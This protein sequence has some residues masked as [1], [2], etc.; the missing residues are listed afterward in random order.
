M[1]TAEKPAQA[2]VY[3]FP[4]DIEKVFNEITSAEYINARS[5]WIGDRAEIDIKDTANGRTVTLD[6]YVA[7]DYPKAFRK[8]FPPEQHMAHSETWERDGV[9]FKGDYTVNVSG[10]PVVV[11]CEFTLKKTGIGCDLAIWH[12][13]A[14]KIPLLGGR[15]E[16]YIIK[17]TRAQFGDQLH[18]LDMRLKG[19]PNLIPRD[20]DKYPVPH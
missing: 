4:H 10:A 18:F 3:Q 16:K 9:N 6:R 14:A 19:T 15:I 5:G 17:E 11:S 20:K 7:K 13:V 8:L 1:A 2:L 12:T